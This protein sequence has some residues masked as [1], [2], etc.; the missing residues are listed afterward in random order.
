MSSFGLTSKET[1]Q[2][3]TKVGAPKEVYRDPYTV[4]SR[5]V[6]QFRGFRKKYYIWDRGTRV[7]LIPFHNGRVLMTRQYRFL[8]NR[9]TLEIPGGKA[10]VGEKLKQAAIRECKEETGFECRKV[11]KLIDYHPGLDTYFNPTALFFSSQLKSPKENLEENCAWISL[12]EALKGIFSGVINDSFSIIGL[13]AL[14]HHI[15]KK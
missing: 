10:E 11:K 3:P 14:N 1:L 5:Q 13:L 6:A 2:K 4:I 8:A 7:G 15:S 12:S 9:I